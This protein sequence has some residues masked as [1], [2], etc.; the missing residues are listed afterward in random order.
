MSLRLKMGRRSGLGRT[1]R[2]GLAVRGR[3]SESIRKRSGSRRT[4]STRI[5]SDM[6]AARRFI[7]VLLY[8]PRWPGDGTADSELFIKSTQFVARIE[9]TEKFSAHACRAGVCPKLPRRM[10]ILLKGLQ[11]LGYF[12]ESLQ[13][14]PGSI[15][16][17][18]GSLDRRSDRQLYRKLLRDLQR[19]EGKIQILFRVA[20]VVITKPEGTIREV[21]FP[22]VEEESAE[23]GDPE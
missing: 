2:A 4:R 7:G 3:I 19:V 12:P 16:S 8:H 22:V 6:G 11:Y 15:R 21:L 9:L 18:M 1:V 10:A 17:F 20:E 13:Q 14:V 23:C 5:N